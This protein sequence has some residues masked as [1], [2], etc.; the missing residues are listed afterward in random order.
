M[1]RFSF[2]RKMAYEIEFALVLQP[3]ADR[4]ATFFIKKR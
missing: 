3:E 1:M 4:F 2:N